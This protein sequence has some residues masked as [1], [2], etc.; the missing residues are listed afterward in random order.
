MRPLAE[1]TA[2]DVA[3]IEGV[4][5][6]LDDTLLTAGELTLEAYAALH[7][8]RQAGFRLVACTGRPAGWGELVV[9][10]WPIEL[11][12][13]ENG[14]IGVR[15]SAVGVVRL[16]RLAPAARARRRERLRAVAEQMLRLEPAAVLADDHVAR[17]SDLTFDVGEHQRL[18]PGELARLRALAESLGVRTFVSS[19]HLHVSYDTDDKA[20]GTLRALADRLGVDPT[21]ARWR[22]A[23]VGDSAN[24]A[25]CFAAFRLSVGV[26]NVRPHLGAITVAPRFVSPSPCGAGFAE[27]AR[28]LVRLRTRAGAGS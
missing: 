16:D 7:Q 27:V 12:L 25:P 8:L 28:E 1:L 21:R 9:R 26:H 4:V 5:F 10:Q 17:V 18:S 20:S 24:D 15:R 23:Y 2:S 3:P 19:I 11:A 13:T 22:Y 6:D 14:A